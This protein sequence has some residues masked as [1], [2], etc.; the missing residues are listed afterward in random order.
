[1]G[2]TRR[3]GEQARGLACLYLT[4]VL[5]GAARTRKLRDRWCKSCEGRESWPGVGRAGGRRLPP[6]GPC[7][8]AFDGGVAPRIDRAAGPGPG[9]QRC[10]CLACSFLMRHQ[11]NYL[12][13]KRLA[14]PGVPALDKS[15]SKSQ[16]ISGCWTGSSMC[17]RDGS[18]RA[19]RYAE[20]NR[21]GR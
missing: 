2:P 20:I 5:M 6:L 7:I 11:W 17:I 15:S 13:L 4:G 3:A 16:N 10:V 9:L 19:A 1:M 14:C 21:S 12:P 8:P 18:L